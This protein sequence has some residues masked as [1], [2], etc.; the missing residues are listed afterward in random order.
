MA[1]ILVFPCEEQASS[2]APPRPGPGVLLSPLRCPYPIARARPAVCLFKL[3]SRGLADSGAVP[4]P[5]IWG[6]LTFLSDLA[7][8]CFIFSPG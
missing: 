2:R 3:E 1:K 7:V 4:F 8:F 6:F 5:H